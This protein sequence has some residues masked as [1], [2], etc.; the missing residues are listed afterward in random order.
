MSKMK[1]I[2]ICTPSLGAVSVWWARQIAELIHPLNIGRRVCFVRDDIGGQIAET[3]NKIVADAMRLENDRMEIDS[4]FWVDDDVLVSRGAL[5]QLYGH[6]RPIAS[7]VYFLKGDPSVPLLMPGRV[8]GTDPFV[9]NKV[10]DCWGV[11][12]GLCLVKMDVYRRMLAGGLPTDK[13]GN[14][15]WYKT[16]KEYSLQGDMLDSG[17]TED[18][19]FLDAAQ[20]VDQAFKPLAD[21]GKWAFGWHYDLATHKGWP[22]PQFKQWSA[23]KKVVWETKDGTV[24]WE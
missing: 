14:P 21:C 16:V 8:Q 5:M 6:H 10:Y 3:R 18:L 23:G 12:M 4:L 9:P 20:K 11:G 15:E 24:E 17:G 1:C 2:V 22:E 7:G 13:L 19:Y